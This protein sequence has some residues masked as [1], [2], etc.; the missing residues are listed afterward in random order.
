MA[1]LTSTALLLLCDITVDVTCSSVVC[2]IIVMLISSL[3]CHNLVTPLS[4]VVLQYCNLYYT[5]AFVVKSLMGIQ[6]TALNI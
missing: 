2:E 4:S 5:I 6:I 1:T 3:L